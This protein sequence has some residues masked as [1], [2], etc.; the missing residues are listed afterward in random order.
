MRHIIGA[1]S[2]KGLG[3][4]LLYISV[5]VLK[6]L[7]ELL[8]KVFEKRPGPV[9]SFEVQV[10]DGHGLDQVTNTTA[11]YFTAFPAV[12]SLFL[13]IGNNIADSLPDLGALGHK[14]R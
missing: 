4:L 3:C 13:N 14:V 1:E 6:V 11:H 9:S 10:S 12:E 5:R 7:L 2:L 8:K